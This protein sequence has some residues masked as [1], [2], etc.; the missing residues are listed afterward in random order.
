M[1]I[2][3]IIIQ[4]SAGRGPSECCWV[5]S[6]CLKR[7]IS[8]LNKKDLKVIID[9]TV[10]GSIKGTIRSA[11]I[12]VEGLRLNK[13][14]ES[15]CGTVLWIGNSPFR[16]YHKRKNWFISIQ[17]MES[18]GAKIFNVRDVQFETFRAPGPGGQH[19]NKVET[20]VRAIHIPSGL[21]AISKDSR[22]Q[23]LNKKQA[24][25]RL[26]TMLVQSNI[27]S[28]AD[29][30]RLNWNQHTSIKRGDPVKVFKGSRFTEVK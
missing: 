27:N 14:I 3:K 7:F 5:V 10:A 12:S 6:Q 11:V 8:H 19:R 26:E 13:I 24:L 17:K 4:I 2:Q 18:R 21:V 1:K 9:S 15:W 23:Y 20:A 28:N 25:T 22:S 16:K 30:A 29:Q